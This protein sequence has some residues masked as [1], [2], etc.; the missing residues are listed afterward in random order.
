MAAIETRSLSKVYVTS[1]GNK[2]VRAL[3][4]LN[5]TIEKGT[6]FGMLGPN[7]AG[8]TTLVKLLLQI[9][10]PTFGTARLLDTDINDYHLKKKIGYL[11]ENHK[12]PPY[13]SGGAVLKYFGKLSNIN[14]LELDK[15]IDELLELV[16]LSKWKKAK[17]KTYSKGMMQR[18][19]LAQALINDPELI[20]LD[21]PTDGVDPIGRK[22]IRDI[23]LEL[24]SRSKTIF[25]NSHLLSEVELITD[26]VGILNKGK[27]LRE[28]TV[29]EL[30]EKKEE[31]KITVSDEEFELTRYS[32]KNM[33]ITKSNSG[34]YSVKVDDIRTM[35][36][37]VDKLR[38]DSVLIKEI[39]LQKDTLEEMFISLISQEEKGIEN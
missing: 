9:I 3:N 24:K 21:E 20:F 37:L 16:N 4:E 18:L 39:V 13:L 6:I 34:S 1:F 17:V 25:L 7:G 2:K 22:E 38:N 5:L 10:F 30:T 27:L 8:K 33:I 28:G 11:P 31:Y 29:R 23:L 35:N 14:G 19:G 12:Y 32:D 15:K 26:R 36:L